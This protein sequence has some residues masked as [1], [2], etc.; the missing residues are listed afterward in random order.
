MRHRKGDGKRTN[1]WICYLQIVVLLLSSLVS[2]FCVG[3]T[4]NAKGKYSGRVINVVYD[5]S[6]S[7]V[8]DY[9]KNEMIPRWSQA[10]YS[11]EVFTAMLG[12]NDVMNIY[13][14]SKEGGLGYTLKGTDPNRVKT[15][16]DMNGVY[17]NTPFE[18]V[19]AAGK[20]LL[21]TSDDVERWLVIITDGAFD[22]GATP[23]SE[24]QSTID[25]YLQ[26]GIKVAYLAI[27]DDASVLEAKPSQGFFTE[28]A[29][30]GIDVLNKV[31]SIANQIFSHL[32]LPKDCI[33]NSGDTYTLSF[34]IPTDQ[35]IVFAQG[36]NATIGK[37]TQD[38]KTIEATEVE[39]VKYSDVIP[40]NSS[41]K[42]AVIDTSLKG[43]V[44]SFVSGSSPYPDGKFSVSVSGAKTVE[45]Y[46][47]P[48]V[49]VNAELLYDGAPV[50][51][52]ADL[53]EG[54]YEVSMNFMNPLTNMP[55]DSKLLADAVFSL[56]ISNNGENQQMNSDHGNIHLKEGGVELVATAELPGQ[57]VLTDIKNYTVLPQPLTLNLDFELP[58]NSF[59]KTEIA[60][61]ETKVK[62]KVTNAEDGRLLTDEEWNNTVVKVS[63]VGG[64]SWDVNKGD[65]V[66][67]WILTSKVSGGTEDSVATGIMSIV[68][69][70][71]FQVDGQYA[72]G[73]GEFKVNIIEY[74]HS[75]MILEVVEKPEF[76]LYNLESEPGIVV[77]AY[78]TNPKTKEKEVASEELWNNMTLEVSSESKMDFRVEKGGTVGDYVIHPMYYETDKNGWLSWIP[79][80]HDRKALK[81]DSG[82]ISLHI[83]G[84][85]L[86]RDRLY[87]GETDTTFNVRELSFMEKFSVLYPVLII[88]AVLLFLIIGY[89]VKKR[90]PK[91]RLKPRVYDTKGNPGTKRKIKKNMVTV[92]LPYVSEKAKVSCK[93]P[94]KNGENLPNI[95]I[96]A[97]T[98]S[99][100]KILSNFAVERYL[101][102]G[103]EYEKEDGMKKIKNKPFPYG[104][105][106]I[107]ALDEK[108]HELGTF[109]FK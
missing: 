65:E 32:V 68:A 44:A 52:D 106:S 30:D 27:G 1:R 69:S 109:R 26:S 79:K 57:V 55:V 51:Q 84:D 58:K 50:M 24:V 17:R 38:G 64:I 22:D 6:G 21:G 9:N 71:D 34:D 108:N 39:N 25:T 11:L 93:D 28:K 73:T 36:D 20:N 96:K 59:T 72:H 29:A 81:T 18:T 46:Y 7:M 47:K 100:F 99:S 56:D 78:I 86:E 48:G 82:Q 101:V 42:D 14:M 33:S 60:N 53:Y 89:I 45:F 95:Q 87:H 104:A 77:R 66:S 70:A 49:V 12:E 43:V 5:D 80:S 94:A 61:G 85:S 97:V 102:C 74:A 37:L 54:D 105:F 107:T 92:L 90:I 75:E 103:V 31:T 35:I 23:L 4:V 98:N 83:V 41:Y 2:L 19:K 15:V 62:L 67:T 3:D 16:H 91:R 63:E 88:L 76:S 40:E 10:K 13:P 8:K